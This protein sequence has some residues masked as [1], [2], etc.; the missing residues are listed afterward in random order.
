MI[1][2]NPN[3]RVTRDCT[4]PN[5]SGSRDSTPNPAYCMEWT[6]NPW[7]P[8]QPKPRPGP[9]CVECLARRQGGQQKQWL[10]DL[11]EWTGL[12]IPDTVSPAHDRGTYLRYA[13][14]SHSSP[15]VEGPSRAALCRGRYLR[16]ETLEFRHL[17]C[18]VL[19]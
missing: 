9:H 13:H 8:I 5:P 10:G 7:L 14:L 16:G 6:P 15:V 3:S 19:A 11:R 1:Y 18:N 4:T 12:V 2:L 17:H